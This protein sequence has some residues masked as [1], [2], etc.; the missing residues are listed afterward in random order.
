M[1]CLA[2]DNLKERAKTLKMMERMILG[3]DPGTLIC[4]YGFI[5]CKESGYE[6][7]DYGCIK[8]PPK[9][10]LSDR[11]LIIF[12]SLE[13]LI[14]KYSPSEVAVETQFVNENPQSTIKLS[15]ARCAVILA[16]KKKGLPVFEYSPTKAKLAV[17]GSGRGSKY[18]VQKMVQMLLHLKTAPEPEDAADALALA[19]CHA[20][21][22]PHLLA[23]MEI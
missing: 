4:G 20:N 3:V 2:L 5:L 22:A 6:A 21:C 1:I 17:V 11:Y 14:E 9:A 10:K 19:I 13:E 8:P 23:T 12:E 7:V 15:M 16:A 18:Q